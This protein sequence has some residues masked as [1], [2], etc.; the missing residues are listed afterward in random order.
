MALDEDNFDLCQLAIAGMIGDYQHRSGFAQYN[1]IVVDEAVRRGLIVPMESVTA[2]GD[3]ADFLTMSIDPYLKGLTGNRE[4]VERALGDMPH[5]LELGDSDLARRLEAL[6][7]DNL[8]SNN[9]SQGEID[10]LLRTRWW[11][12]DFGVDAG[13]LCDV[14]DACGRLDRADLSLGKPLFDGFRGAIIEQFQEVERNGVVQ[15]EN[16]QYFVHHTPSSGGLI[17]TAV[18]KFFGCDTKPVVALMDMGDFINLSSRSNQRILDQGIALNQVLTAVAPAHG[19]QCGGH[20][21]ASGGTLLPGTM[22]A[23]LK[24][25]DA[26]MGRAKAARGN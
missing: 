26:E 11:L 3:V 22:E 14:L 7:V 13:C 4:A 9:V 17:A 21:K 20:P 23:F 10:G 25:L 1:R 24:D 8:R 6:V 2:I 15:M 12:R 16:L 19:A 5:T 18:L